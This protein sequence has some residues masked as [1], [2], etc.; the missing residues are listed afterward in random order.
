MLIRERVNKLQQ[1]MKEKGIDAYIIPSSDAH[2]SE[3]VAPHWTGRKWITGFTGSAGTAV[4]TLKSG[5]G[6]WTDG[7]YFIQAEKQ[8][9]GSTIDL[10][11]MGQPSVPTISKWLKDNLDENSTIGFDGK[12][13]SKSFFDNLDKELN[14]KCIKYNLDNDLIDAL[15]K[16]RDPIPMGEFYSLDVKYSGKSR[17]DKI[18]EVKEYL[19]ESGSTHYVL[20]SLDDIA[21]LF[22]IRGD[23][24][25]CNPVVISYA[26][27]SNNEVVLFVDSKKLTKQMKAELEN[28]SI[29]IKEY[30]D[31]QNYLV[32]LNKD[33]IITYDPMKTNMWIVNS[34]GSDIKTKEA[35]NVTTKLKAV[36]NDIELQN[37]KNSHI[38]DG[39]AMVRFLH[40]LDTHLGKEKITEITV[41]DKL[42][43]FRSKGEN[44]KGLSFTTIAGYKDHAAMMHYSATKD[45]AYELEKE[46]MILI[47]SGGQYLDGTTD[48]TRTIVLGNLTAEEKRDFTLV[49]KGVINLSIAKF[50]HGATGANLDVLARGPLWKYGIDYKCG[51]G[52]GV[53]FFLN[54][55]EGP[56]GFRQSNVPT[57]LEAGMNITNEPGVY[58]EGKHGIRTENILVVRD[59]E[60]TES[61]RFMNFETITFCPI[62]LDGIDVELLTS[63]ERAWLNNYHK[64][65]YVKLSKYLDED[66]RQWLRYQTRAI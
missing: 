34:L 26:V 8:L 1:L 7:R 14:E 42:E 54:V 2:Q 32:K 64:D 52:H 17:L 65:V 31:L 61:G 21:W 30:T 19:K 46:G 29:I 11:K 10:F 39:V 12:V 36:K 55:H 47:D 28:D 22:N 20:S 48:I 40:W 15:W 58:K 23:D 33:C 5:N 56:H 62:S 44:F 24:V 50:L 41:A 43:E 4:I 53:G 27:V 45:T 18:Q 49:L 66:E 57:V 35:L 3:Y 25:P 63:E 6:L 51:T 60:T 38:R 9:E 59:D 37:M 16:D 13:I